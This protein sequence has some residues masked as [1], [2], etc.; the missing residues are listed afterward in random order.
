MIT[1]YKAGH[2]L[3]LFHIHFEQIDNLNKTKTFLLGGGMRMCI[4]M[5]LARLEIITFIATRQEWAV[6]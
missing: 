3:A 5:H 1:L 4:G 2:L 6:L